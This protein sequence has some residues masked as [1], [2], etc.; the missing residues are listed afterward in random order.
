MTAQSLFTFNALPIQGSYLITAFTQS[1]E[2]GQFSV[3]YAHQTWAQQR[4]SSEIA[5]INYVHNPSC[6]TLR[7]MH[8]QLAPVAEI[9]TVRCLMGSIYDVILDIRISSPTYRQWYGVVL[10]N[11]SQMVYIPEGCAHGYLTLM[12]DT[13]VLYTT[14]KHYVPEACKGIRWNDP[15]F[16]IAWP[17]TPQIIATRDASYANYYPDN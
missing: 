9:K 17:E 16:N 10:D 5:Q 15:A 2:R 3:L 12:S 13:T 8:Y 1:D 6:L 7:G 4:L 14:S 11:P